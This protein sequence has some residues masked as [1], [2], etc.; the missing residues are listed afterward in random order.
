MEIHALKVGTIRVDNSHSG[1]LQP[2]SIIYAS[3]PKGADGQNEAGGEQ[4]AQKSY[5]FH[6][7]P[8]IIKAKRYFIDFKAKSIFPILNS[9]N[10]SAGVRSPRRWIF[11]S[12]SLCQTEWHIMSSEVLFRTEWGSFNAIKPQSNCF[13]ALLMVHRYLSPWGQITPI[14]CVSSYHYFGLKSTEE[15]IKPYWS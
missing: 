13:F 15:L 11:F 4:D 14:S 6:K 5:P 10:F 8:P 12:A 1:I 7:D 9:M 3:H 2:V